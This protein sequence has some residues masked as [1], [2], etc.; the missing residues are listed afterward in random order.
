MRADDPAPKASPSKQRQPRADQ[1]IT[2]ILTQNKIRSHLSINIPEERRDGDAL[3][4]CGSIKSDDGYYV[5][6]LHRTHFRVWCNCTGCQTSADAVVTMSMQ[7]FVKMFTGKT[8]TLEVES[9]DTTCKVKEKIQDKEG[10]PT[11]QQMLVF[12]DKMLEEC[13]PLAIYN[14]QK[15]FNSPHDSQV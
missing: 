1:R 4:S 13:R 3:G 12:G 2:K 14:I 5:A 7:I 10:I 11:Y 6:G 8:L 15:K 9:S